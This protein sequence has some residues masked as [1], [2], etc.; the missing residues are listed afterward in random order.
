MTS[1]S[2]RAFREPFIKFAVVDEI[3][4][5]QQTRINDDRF[6]LLVTAAATAAVLCEYFQCVYFNGST[7]WSFTLVSLFDWLFYWVSLPLFFSFFSKVVILLLFVGLMIILHRGVFLIPSMS[8]YGYV[9]FVSISSKKKKKKKK[10]K[11]KKKTDFLHY[12]RSIT[13]F[14]PT[15]KSA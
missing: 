7:N 1:A 4:R 14:Y 12:H 3:D 15:P 8:S 2:R 13:L 10:K 11:E 6:I 9:V 5:R